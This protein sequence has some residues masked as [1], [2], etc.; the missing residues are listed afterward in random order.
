[1]FIGCIALVDGVV[2][3][4]HT[5]KTQCVSRHLSV[6]FLCCSFEGNKGQTINPAG[7]DTTLFFTQFSISLRAYT[8]SALHWWT[9]WLLDEEHRQSDTPGV[10]S[11]QGLKP[12][13]WASPTRREPLSVANT[14]VVSA[15]PHRAMVRKRQS[16]KMHLTVDW[17]GY[18]VRDVAPFVG[19]SAHVFPSVVKGRSWDLNHLVEILHSCGRSNNE[20]LAIFGPA[21]MRSRPWWWQIR[22]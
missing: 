17:N 20:I 19:S 11:P 3:S 1:M 12:N 21:D 22:L 9:S 7:V 15:S 10:R 5:T 16:L 6:G 13:Q 14:Q 2:L 18:C 4:A 8:R